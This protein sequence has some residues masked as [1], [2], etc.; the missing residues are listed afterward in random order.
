MNDIYKAKEILKKYD[1]NHIVNLFDKISEKEQ[2][3][4]AN[5]VFSID[6]EQIMALYENTKIHIIT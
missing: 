1:Q 2:I 5:Q 4:L 3:E 6:F